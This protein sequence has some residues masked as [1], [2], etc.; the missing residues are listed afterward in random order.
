MK[1]TRAGFTLIELIAALGIT[2]LI[3]YFF[4]SIG[5][6]FV[7]AWGHVGD[8]VSRETEGRAAMDTIARD[9]EA[10]FFREGTDV[11][12]AVD[13]LEDSTNAGT[14]WESGAAERPSGTGF[15]PANHE[16]GWAGC[17]VRLF[18]A[19]PSLNAVGYQIIRST[20]KDGVGTPR[21]MLYR[22]VELHKNVV[23]NAETGADYDLA[24]AVYATSG[25]VTLPDR[26]NILAVN[27]I[28]FGAR[29]YVYDSSGTGDPSGVDAPDGLRLIF[30]ANASSLL[31]S[32]VSGLSH[33]GKS[34]K[35]AAPYS[36]RYPDVVEIFI[37][38]L[39]EGGADE[40]SDME[41]A[42]DNSRWQEVVDN[43]S[44]LYRRYITIG[45]RGG[46]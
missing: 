34:F 30:P 5:R 46:V 2:A 12:F 42:G 19:A 18:T 23:S 28:D 29:L 22:N 7:I 43:N 15:D 21:Y 25:Y 4:I 11:M 9:F 45:G 10:A 20:I 6:D 37:R 16:Y 39:S 26:R 24:N 17:W 32:S 14:K 41:E 44:R 27:V 13:V 1:T 3:G 8:S 31:E 35:E 40:L 33:E 36:Q 38:V